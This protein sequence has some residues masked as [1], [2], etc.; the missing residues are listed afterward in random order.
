M[1]GTSTQ[2][3]LNQSSSRDS[4]LAHLEREPGLTVEQVATL[5]GIKRSASQQLLSRMEKERLVKKADGIKPYFYHLPHQTRYNNITY[6]HEKIGGDIYVY[7]QELIEYW[8]YKEQA[9]FKEYKLKPD[10]QSVMAGKIIMWELDR[11]TMTQ[12]KI[13]QKIEKYIRFA[14]ET[15][16]QFNVAF[17]TTPRRAKSIA[18]SFARYRN[19]DVW[20]TAV[21]VSELIQNPLSEVFLTL[22]NRRLFIH[23]LV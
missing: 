7:C 18:E 11:A 16:K 5:C 23:Q 20:F 13:I 2:E 8:E 9:D 22:N 17:A 12:A 4:V 19:P 10:R 1:N 3:T 15:G 14:V 6:K 21:D